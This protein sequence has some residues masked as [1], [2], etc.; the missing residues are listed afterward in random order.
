MRIATAAVCFALF[1]CGENLRSPTAV[2]EAASAATRRRGARHP[3]EIAPPCLS[4][5]PLAYALDP[6]PG[7]IFTYRPGTD[8]ATTTAQLAQKYGFTA[9]H[10]FS[11]AAFLGFSAIVDSNTVA[12]LRCEP[13]ILRVEQDGKIYPTSH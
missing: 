2:S 7:Y 5:A 13:T 12:A 8:A 6:A 4:P 3:V 11:G 9:T 10:V 1:A